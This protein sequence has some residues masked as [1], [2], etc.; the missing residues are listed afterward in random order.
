MA[1][2]Q[3]PDA[4]AHVPPHPSGPQ[5]FA[6]QLGV[7][8]HSSVEASQLPVAQ[9]QVAPHPSGPQWPGEQLGTQAAHV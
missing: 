5:V 3:V 2:S 7:Q 1:P 9:P 8:T 4:H 6:G